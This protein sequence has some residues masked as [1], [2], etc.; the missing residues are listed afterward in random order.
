MIIGRV[1]G[2]VFRAPQKHIAFAVNEEGENFV[3]FAGQ[4]ASMIWPELEE[5]GGNDLG[6]VLEYVSG[7]KTYY[8]LVCHTQE[9]G[10]WDNT[11]EIVRECLD[12]IDIPNN[13]EIAVVLMGSGEIGIK[14]G[15]DVE[16]ILQGMEQSKKH[17]V[18][19]TL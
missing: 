16:A 13:E 12:N 18:V 14:E 4:V 6:E 19:Y 2:D 10:G 7:S 15:A 5:T 11:P 1:A 9:L 8:A 17:L 3:G